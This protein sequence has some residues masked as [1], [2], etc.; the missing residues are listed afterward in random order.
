M[1]APRG[2]F[3]RLQ[4]SSRGKDTTTGHWELAGVVGEHPMPTYPEG[5]PPAIIAALEASIGRKLICNKPYSGTQVIHDYGREHVETG[6]LIV[7]TSADSVLQLAAHED[8][9]PREELYEAC[10]RARAI[11][12]GKH[13]VGRVIVP[14]SASIQT[15]SARRDGTTS[16]WNR[17][18]PCSTP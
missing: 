5:F 15:T 6:A 3:A 17:R 2:A 10:R 14:S 8:V 11:M 7:Y 4:E 13:G 12:C 18:R 9:V 16:R 1:T